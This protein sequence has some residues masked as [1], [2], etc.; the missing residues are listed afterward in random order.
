MKMWMI[1]VLVATISIA[2]AIGWVMNLYKLTKCDF[3]A[4]YKCEVIR[5]VGLIPIVGCFTGW[6]DIE[7]GVKK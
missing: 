1:M 4:P 6:M 7:D 2:P 3:E 5:A